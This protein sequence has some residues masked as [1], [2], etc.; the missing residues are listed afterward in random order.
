MNVVVR[1]KQHRKPPNQ[2]LPAKI[3]RGRQALSVCPDQFIAQ[4]AI[5]IMNERSAKFMANIGQYKL[6]RISVN[7][8]RWL[9]YDTYQRRSPKQKQF[10][11]NLAPVR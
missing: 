8:F 7:L 4:S 3:K 11:V 1:C 10:G 5:Q 9:Q 2:A 6:G